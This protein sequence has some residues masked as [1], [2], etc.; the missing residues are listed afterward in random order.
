MSSRI[1]KNYASPQNYLAVLSS[2]EPREHSTHY[3]VND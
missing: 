3:V 2:F 1:L